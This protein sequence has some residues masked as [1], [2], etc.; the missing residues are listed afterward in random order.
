VQIG[1]L[2]GWAKLCADMARPTKAVATEGG[3]ANWG[4]DAEC[5]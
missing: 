1:Q 4:G 5:S 3:A 2:T